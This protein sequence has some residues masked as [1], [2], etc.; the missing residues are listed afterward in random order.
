M[1][2]RQIGPNLV[3]ATHNKGK[4]EE[5]RALCAPYKI[6]VVSAG[7]LNLPEP[8][9]TGMTFEENALLKARAAAQASNLPALADDSGLCVE[10]LD[11]APGVYSARWAGA[12]KD[13][14]FA[15]QRIQTALK[16]KNIETSQAYFA[17][18]LALAFPD[19]KTKIFEGRV[20]GT[21]AFPP[22]GRKGFGYDPI[23][24]PEGEIQTFA[25][26]DL[27]MKQ[28][29][30]HRARAFEDFAR[31]VLKHEAA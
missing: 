28:R 12:Q 3:L 8:E 22:R 27:A 29:M 9:E 26:M 2:A 5:V 4:L 21:L 20:D 24:I 6:S 16:E 7:E 19:G 15:M 30:S 18:V 11:G 17:C 1:T 23:F 14:T 13:F 10:A 31:A 25:E